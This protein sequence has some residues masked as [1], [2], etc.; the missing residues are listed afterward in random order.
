M[1]QRP[2][3]RADGRLAFD[4]QT[5][6]DHAGQGPCGYWIPFSNGLEPH[7]RVRGAGNPDYDP[8]F[9]HRGLADYLIMARGFKGRTSLHMLEGVLN[10]DSPW[11][12]DG[13]VA[14]ALGA[15]VRREYY[16]RREYSEETG[17]RGGALQDLERYP[18]RGG[19]TITDCTSGRTGVFVYLPPVT[20]PRPT[21]PS[22]PCSA[23]RRCR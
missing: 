3:L 6:R 23:R 19:P 5:L 21:V 14:Y 18:C 16:R 15:Q 11:H 7:V 4:W 13:P 20:T 17:P 9:D 1:D 2:P 10:G 8:Q 12:L 22:T